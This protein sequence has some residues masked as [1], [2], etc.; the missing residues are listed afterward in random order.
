MKLVFSFKRILNFTIFLI[1]ATVVAVETYSCLRKYLAEPQGT[2]ISVE[3]GIGRVFPQFTICPSLQYSRTHIFKSC[4][5]VW[6]NVYLGE[7]NNLNWWPNDTEKCGTTKDLFDHLFLDMHDVIKRAEVTY[8]NDTKIRIYPNQTEFWHEH[9]EFRIGRCFVFSIFAEDKIS[10]I[11]FH[12]KVG[13]YSLNVYYHSPGLFK[14]VGLM[15]R[16]SVD[17]KAKFPKS[18]GVEI[19][20]DYDVYKMLDFGG[21]KCNDTQNYSRDNCTDEQLY[22]ES[23]KKIN[24]TWPFLPFGI[25]RNAS[26]DQI[27]KNESQI[28]MMT[29]QIAPKYVQKKAKKCLD[30][31]N[32]LRIFAAETARTSYN[33]NPKVIFHFAETVN[34]MTAY[35]DY[36]GISMVAEIGGYVGLFLGISFYQLTDVITYLFKKMF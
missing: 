23:I 18:E 5:L 34:V 32:Y 21:A 36:T 19:V 27:C 7:V 14:T 25:M 1:C 35:Y 9:Y 28:E 6:Y 3:D 13:A 2:H 22:E 11:S 29:H 10:K 12:F 16:K 31:C 8:E 20:V 24:C 17:V 15:N 30:P 4:G 33:P 26:W